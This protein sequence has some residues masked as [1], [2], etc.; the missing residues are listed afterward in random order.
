MTEE[1]IQKMFEIQDRVRAEVSRIES[2]YFTKPVSISSS[3]ADPPQEPDHSLVPQAADSLSEPASAL[4]L[5]PEL[6]LKPSAEEP[7]PKPTW[8]LRAPERPDAAPDCPSRFFL[9]PH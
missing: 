2:L 3:E 7:A 8:P 4:D 5:T 6:E 1:E 9:L